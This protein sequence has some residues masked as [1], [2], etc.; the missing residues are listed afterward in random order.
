MTE[1]VESQA[2][3]DLELQLLREQELANL[4]H[5]RDYVKAVGVA[6]SLDQPYKVLTILQGVIPS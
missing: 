5:Q 3:A 2:T 1:Q 6:I 4:L